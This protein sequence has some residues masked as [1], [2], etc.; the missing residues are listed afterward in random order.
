LEEKS[1]AKVTTEHTEEREV[2]EK[3][4]DKEPIQKSSR[5][6]VKILRNRTKGRESRKAANKP[7]SYRATL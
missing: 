4:S 3:R 1:N 7:V 5:K 6:P 2:T